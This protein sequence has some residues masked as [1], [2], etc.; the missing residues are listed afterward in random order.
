MYIS[1]YK[2]NTIVRRKKVCTCVKLINNYI[3]SL[4]QIIKRF[5]FYLVFNLVWKKNYNK[6]NL[7]IKKKDWNL[8]KSLL[9]PL[10]DT[11]FPIFFSFCCVVVDLFVFKI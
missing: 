11:F 4:V 7:I 3:V 1:I 5:I 9:L 10:D 8:K 2:S 6:V